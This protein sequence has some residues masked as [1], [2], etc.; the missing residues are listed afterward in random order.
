MKREIASVR[1]V[2]ADVL[3]GERELSEILRVSFTTSRC[4]IVGLVEERVLFHRRG[5]GT[6][7]RRSPPRVEQVLSRLTSF[8]ED[9]RSRGFAAS[10][11]EIERGGS[12]RRLRRR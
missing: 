12:C 3:P 10:S 9:M 8:T 1:F 4:A 7:V 2:G 11:R 5:V 6:F